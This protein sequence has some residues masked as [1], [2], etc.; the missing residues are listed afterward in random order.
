MEKYLERLS[1][2]CW[3]YLENTKN[4]PGIHF[5]AKPE[6]CDALLKCVEIP[7]SMPTGSKRTILLRR[8]NPTDEQKITGGQ[9]FRDFVKLHIVIHDPGDELRQ[10]CITEKDGIVSIDLVRNNTEPFETGLRDVKAGTGDRSIG[11]RIDKK[12]G[13]SLGPLDEQSDELWFWPCFGHLWKDK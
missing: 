12:H 3:G 1:V 9:R 7:R 4:Y 8:L 11:P 13:L 10:M 2:W 6:A 5:T